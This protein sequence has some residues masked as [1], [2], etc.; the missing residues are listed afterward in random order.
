MRLGAIEILR[1]LINNTSKVL[2]SSKFISKK[3]AKEMS[4]AQN[5]IT[6]GLKDILL[7]DQLTI[8][9]KVIFDFILFFDRLVF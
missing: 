4:V 1:H 5:I 3:L 6:M 2:L 8:R 9:V 7:S